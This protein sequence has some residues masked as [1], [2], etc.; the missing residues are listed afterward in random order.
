[1]EENQAEMFL[2]QTS[3]LRKNL[4]ALWDVKNSVE[5]EKTTMMF[6]TFIIVHQYFGFL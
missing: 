5:D 6:V 3:C 2:W 1:M 4:C